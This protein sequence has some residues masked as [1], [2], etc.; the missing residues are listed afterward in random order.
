MLKKARERKVNRGSWTNINGTN[1]HSPLRFFSFSEIEV[2]I[3]LKLE[4]PLRDEARHA[5]KSQ[6]K[7]GKEDRNFWNA[8]ASSSHFGTENAESMVYF[9]E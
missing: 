6:R 5:E 2:R 1:C 9:S 7:E 3:S 4:V 8:P